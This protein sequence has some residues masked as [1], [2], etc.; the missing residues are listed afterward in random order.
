MTGHFQM[1]LFKS[2]LKHFSN[3]SSTSFLTKLFQYLPILTIRLLY[4]Y[5]YFLVN[6]SLLACLLR[7]AFIPC[8][9]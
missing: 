9:Q 1:A 8:S 5:Y 2:R 4:Y 6:L 3:R 7:S